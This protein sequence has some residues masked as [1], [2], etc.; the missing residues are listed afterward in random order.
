[1]LI[2]HTLADHHIGTRF[3][4]HLDVASLCCGVASVENLIFCLRFVRLK[5][6]VGCQLLFVRGGP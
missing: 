1:M 4:C 2:K 6:F 3:L 5:I